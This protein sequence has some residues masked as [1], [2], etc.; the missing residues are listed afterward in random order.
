M[1]Q[2]FFIYILL[3]LEEKLYSLKTRH[4]S[5]F[6]FPPGSSSGAALQRSASSGE[7]RAKERERE[8]ERK[9]R[10][11]KPSQCVL[12][13]VSIDKLASKL[14]QPQFQH[15]HYTFNRI[16]IYAYS[17]NFAST[18]HGCFNSLADAYTLRYTLFFPRCCCCCY[19]HET[20]VVMYT[21][22]CIHHHH[23]HHLL[24]HHRH[25]HTP[26]LGVIRL[27]M[28][29]E[30]RREREKKNESGAAAVDALA[31]PVES[32]RGPTR[33]SRA[34]ERERGCA[35]RARVCVFH[36]SISL[37]RV[38]REREYKVAGKK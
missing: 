34:G 17:N 10:P 2:Q 20:C 31:A 28:S 11:V 1:C 36:I 21:L 22:L 33:W 30:E 6:L 27:C 35:A 15:L 4:Y 32:A 26:A 19:L 9:R 14:A 25:R 5:I 38:I 18:L 8:R 3:Y 13:L 29:G 37:R 24:L 12:F 23:H 7:W 16:Y